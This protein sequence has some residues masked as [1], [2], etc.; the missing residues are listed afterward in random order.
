MDITTILLTIQSLLDNNPLHHEPGQ[1]TN[2]TEMN[3]LYNEVIKYESIQTLTIQNLIDP[4]EGFYIFL[5]DM[6][7][8]SKNIA[9]IFKNFY[10]K[11][12]IQ[13]RGN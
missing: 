1:E 5:N 12:K 10:F 6:K 13:K 8:N 2:E 7:E 3:K 4:P 11:I 9:G